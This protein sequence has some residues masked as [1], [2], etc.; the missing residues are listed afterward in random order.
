MS[1][2]D[3]PGWSVQDAPVRQASAARKRKRPSDADPASS[4]KMDSA[5]RNMDKA[6]ASIATGMD[7]IDRAEKKKEK[8]LEKMRAVVK[9]HPPAKSPKQNA[10]GANQSKG[11]LTG[12]GSGGKHAKEPL[13]GPSKTKDNTTRPTKKQK[14]GKPNADASQEM[15]ESPTASSVPPKGKPKA[16]QGL[17]TLQAS[18]KHSL[19][20]ARFRSA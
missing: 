11:K 12:E 1:L 9:S 6:I 10:N 14:K 2:F 19:D 20:G 16:A 3:I 7:A 18:M 8:R 13:A 15:Q 5:K 17:T 4:A